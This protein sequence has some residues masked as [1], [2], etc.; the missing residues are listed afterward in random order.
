M[1]IDHSNIY[2]KKKHVTVSMKPIR[3]LYKNTLFLNETSKQIQYIMY[4]EKSDVC[5]ERENY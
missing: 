3:V 4:N 5:T 1:A 2:N